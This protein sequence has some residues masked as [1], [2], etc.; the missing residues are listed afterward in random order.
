MR[1]ALGTPRRYVGGLML[2]MDGRLVLA[3]L[4]VGII[5]SIAATR[6]LQTQL[7]GV[8]PADP[9]VALRQG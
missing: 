9:M 1:M 8:R 4:V 3:G 7:F 6:L 2:R 5:G